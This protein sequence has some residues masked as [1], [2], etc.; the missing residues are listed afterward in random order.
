MKKYFL[1]CL[2]S[3]LKTDTHLMKQ[4]MWGNSDKDLHRPK[5]PLKQNTLISQ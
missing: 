1:I 5:I 3:D 4:G 2:I